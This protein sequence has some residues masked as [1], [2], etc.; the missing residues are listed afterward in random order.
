MATNNNIV[1]LSIFLRLIKGKNRS[2]LG[3]AR[4][5]VGRLLHT[6]DKLPAATSV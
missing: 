3:V 4:R 2:R 6:G 5:R 1:T